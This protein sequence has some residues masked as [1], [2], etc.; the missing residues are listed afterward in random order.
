MKIA[1]LDFD[2]VVTNYYEEIGSYVTYEPAFYGPSPSCV[3]RLRNLCEE[4]GARILISSNW[5]KFD[6]DGKCS[7]WTHPKYQRTV[8]NPLPKLKEQIGDLIIGTIPRIRHVTK[9]EAIKKWFEENEVDEDFRYVILDDDKNEGLQDDEVFKE[10][11]ILT[12]PEIG[13]SDADY[14]KVL[15]ILA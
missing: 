11:F 3:Q 7:F 12:N 10:H 2:G 6:E 15:K 4:T 13:F 5:R 1:M 8:Q 14:K 9:T